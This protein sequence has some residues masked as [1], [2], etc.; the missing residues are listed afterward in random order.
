MK[1]ILGTFVNLSIIV[2]M[3]F[4]LFTVIHSNT[5]D[6]SPELIE[7][8]IKQKIT[9]LDS[10][11]K[12]FNITKFTN[13][14]H[15]INVS[16]TIKANEHGYTT[17][18]TNI[19]LYNNIVEEINAF[20]FTIPLQEYK[21][22][23]YLHIYSSNG[24]IDT[25]TPIENNDSAILRIKFPSIG[26][27]ELIDINIEMDHP[28]AVSSEIDAILQETSFPYHFNLSF[29]PLISFPITNYQ[30]IW[31]INSG[32]TGIDVDIENDTIQPA[33]N[34]STGVTTIRTMGF[35]IKNITKL[36]SINQSVLNATKYGN[37][38]LTML[39]NREFIP[40]FTPMLSENLTSYLSFNYFHHGGIRLEFKKLITEVTVSEWGTVT[41]EHTITI[42]NNGI[43]S[44]TVLST[45][46]GGPTFPFFTV[47]VPEK[48]TDFSLY[49]KYGNVSASTKRNIATKRIVIEIRP[50]IQIDPGKE[51]NL[52]LSYREK[53]SNI[54][55]D[56]RNGKI[57][58]QIP[59]TMNF[60]WIV[61]E[62]EYK[63]LLPWIST[64]NRT[65]MVERIED[66]TTRYPIETTRTS[67]NELLGLF[68]KEGLKIVFDDFT[69]LS[70]KDITLTFGL[71]PFYPL[72]MP[73]SICVVFF[74]IG[75]AYTIIRNL[76]FGYKGK[77]IKIE[78]IPLDLIKEFVKT[79]EEKTAIREQMLR[80]DRKRKSKNISSRE[81]EKTKKLLKNRQ[82]RADQSIVT[83]SRKL[84]E[85]GPRYR[86][87]MR[88]IEVA[89][90]NR[91]DILKNIDSLERKKNQGRIGKEAYAK[92]KM[93]YNKQLRKANNEIDK[94]LIDL[95]SLL[96]K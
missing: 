72:Y 37:Y 26:F 93:S 42:L 90:A 79:Y 86:V 62:F 81:Y 38:N 75:F 23:K 59:I 45:A 30:L 57:E 64:Y 54:A 11:L 17:T 84:G 48:A 68:N 49:D 1:K 39:E 67:K 18:L 12:Y 5:E 44:G 47:Q 43:K 91:E 61:H 25:L 70:I 66:S 60:D 85:E 19:R 46:L 32:G 78:E 13:T 51:Y 88:S 31:E 21:D 28:S 53:S 27:K 74:I 58:L 52:S 4:S 16:R 89:E 35:D 92:L 34:T 24:T 14:S 20:N 2:L 63:L 73:L 65:E 82:Q 40:A 56:M 22:S 8:Q 87:S 7:N 77:I 55:R 41:T 96:T 36:L 50:R 94:V 10:D 6:I 76:S 15:S 9:L 83:A 95:R 69:P 80:L 71:S 33:D 3:I 29:L